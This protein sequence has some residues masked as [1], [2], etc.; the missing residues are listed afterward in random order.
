MTQLI[1]AICEGGNKV[2]LVSDRLVSRAGLAFERG[3]KGEEIADNAMALT[4]G[5]VHEPELIEEVKRDFSK[6][7]RPPILDIAKRF[8]EKYHEI[9]LARIKDEVLK[10]R[11]FDSLEQYY[12]RQKLLH[13]SVVI[14][15]NTEIEGYDL[16]VLILLAG[17]DSSAHL[18]LIANPGAYSSFDSIGFFCPG[19]GR[20]Q[21]ESTFVWYEFTPELSASETLYIAFEAKK[22]AETAGQVGSAT[23]AWLIDEGGVHAISKRTIER[24]RQIYASREAAPRL[25]K[26]ITELQLP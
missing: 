21:A 20:E 17:V 13:D 6:V 2:V 3:S 24:L 23:D 4:A 19:M 9:R 7:S 15:I 1:G 18:Y 8:T 11:G 25:G 14:D 16:G 22:K 5:T 12:N 10:R 26:E